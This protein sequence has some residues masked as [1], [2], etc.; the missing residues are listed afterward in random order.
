LG[1]RAKNFIIFHH[2][3]PVSTVTYAQRARCENDPL[4]GQALGALVSYTL[5]DNLKII[6]KIEVMSR[7]GSYQI[8]GK[9]GTRSPLSHYS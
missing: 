2:N 9:I 3:Q 4:M 7:P 6:A 1:T 5:F 8:P